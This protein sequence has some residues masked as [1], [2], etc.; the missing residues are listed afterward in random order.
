M[1]GP[2]DGRP[3]VFVHG[4]G[5]GRSLWQPLTAR[6]AQGGLSCIAPTWPLGGHT[7][8]M[9]DCA[10]LTMEGI[11]AMAA[12]FIE[13]LDLDDVVLVGNDTGGAIA[14][15]LATTAPDRLGALVLTGCDAFEHFPPPIMKPLILAARFPT[16][17]R[18]A[19]EPLR[20]RFGRKKAY[21]GLSHTDIDQ[22]VVE[23]TTPAL[24]D[25]RVRGDL[26]RFT[27]SLHRQTMLDAASRLSQ[28]T[29]PA[30]IA[31]SADD[32]FFPVQDG[33]RLASALP[34]ARLEMIKDARTFS[35]IDQ[36]DRLAELMLDFCRAGVVDRAA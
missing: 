18:A 19:L 31:W 20:T 29:K 11:A 1:S 32:M 30:L 33:K 36:P 10:E 27:G 4:Y 22:L 8:A 7:E 35:M 14:Q 13:A 3:L 21:G 9:R 17:F 24:T 23:W 25:A 26:R 16:T 15:V 12:E 28:F 6:L 5:M 34:N 2:V